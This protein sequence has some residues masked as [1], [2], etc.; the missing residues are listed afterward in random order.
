MR[1]NLR[2]ERRLRAHTN[3][4]DRTL[5]ARRAAGPGRRRSDGAG[6]GNGGGVASGGGGEP[7]RSQTV[8][9]PARPKM[10]V[11]V[12]VDNSG[13]MCEE[14][15]VLADALRTV[16]PTLAE[17]D[18]RFAVVSTD[19]RAETDRGKFLTR[20]AEPESLLNCEAA[21]G[22]N[23]PDTSD[24]GAALAAVDLRDGVLRAEEGATAEVL[25][26]ATRCLVTLGTNGDGFEKGLEAMR[27]ALDCEG[28]QREL[29]GACCVEGRFDP[30]CAQAPPFLRPDAGLLV[31]IV[32]DEPDCS[33]PSVNPKASHR[34]I[35]KYGAMP[36]D[37]NG[38]PDGYT[39]PVLCP[40]GD[41]A[42]CFAAECG[43]LS[44]D[45]CYRERCI[46]DRGDNNNCV[47]HRDAL[48]PVADYV[49]F[50]RSLKRRAGLDV[51]VMPIVGPTP[52][53]PTGEELTWIPGTPEAACDPVQPD[54]DPAA[55][56]PMCC[57]EGVCTGNIFPVCQSE[58][59]LAYTGSRYRALARGFCDPDGRDCDAMEQTEICDG[60]FEL[61][62]SLNT[63]LTHVQ[64]RLL[65][66][67]APRRGESIEV[68]RGDTV[69]PAA[70][71]RVEDAAECATGR[72]L[73]LLDPVPGASYV[74]RVLP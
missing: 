57:P 70:D 9:V 27:L 14:Q 31:V 48:T 19:L 69:L 64:R 73:R 18:L 13:S 39:D 36:A 32:S 50:L 5:P 45:E 16:S 44:A 49:D 25:A 30:D 2:L 56:A 26:A 15:G 6:G 34:A 65:P 58:R 67:R 51:R 63:L 54:F 21:G 53:L 42:A 72:A 66:R 28:P 3:C 23:A 62:A 8:T 61:G 43:A 35:C 38:V 33:D 1:R 46:V 29:F 4:A 40:S 41:A 74:V 68:S 24:C 12:V 22:P 20:P 47:W 52:R 60:G 10:D 37:E 71:Y 59:G 7:P 55:D 17:M 11:L